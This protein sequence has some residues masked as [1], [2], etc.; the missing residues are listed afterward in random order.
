MLSDGHIQITPF[1]VSHLQSPVRTADRRI[2]RLQRLLLQGVLET[3]DGVLDLALNLVDLAIG[4][5][6]VS[7]VILPMVSLIESLI[8]LAD[9]A[10]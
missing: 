6:L 8:S 2:K 7:P 3:A 5:S 9:P 1:A 10:I 4:L